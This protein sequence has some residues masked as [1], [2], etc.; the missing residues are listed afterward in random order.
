MQKKQTGMRDKGAVIKE[1]F[2]KEATGICQDTGC[3]LLRSSIF[4]TPSLYT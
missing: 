4:M 3:H 1:S 2:T